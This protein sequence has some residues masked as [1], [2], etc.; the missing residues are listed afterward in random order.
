ML[1]FCSPFSL[2]RS[3]ILTLSVFVVSACMPVITEYFGSRPTHLYQYIRDAELECDDPKLVPHIKQFFRDMI[4][5]S[6]AQIHKRRFPDDRGVPNMWT[7]P[8]FLEHYVRSINPRR[9]RVDRETFYDDLD[10]ME[11]K[12]IFI[13]W[14]QNVERL[15]PPRPV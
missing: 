15:L 8:D 14:S 1:P 6:P 4:Q 12:A 11:V 7:A 13:Y 9:Q 2:I 3:I 10:D 5:Y